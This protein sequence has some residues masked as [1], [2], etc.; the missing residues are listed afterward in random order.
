M[1]V[2]FGLWPPPPLPWACY[3]L[4]DRQ[5]VHSGAAGLGGDKALGC[6]SYELGDSKQAP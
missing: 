6:S 5:R 2:E 3:A 1:K 4:L